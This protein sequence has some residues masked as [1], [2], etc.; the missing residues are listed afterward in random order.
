MLKLIWGIFVFCVKFL[1]WC[2]VWRSLSIVMKGY[3][4]KV[5]DCFEDDCFWIELIELECE[6]LLFVISYDIFLFLL[7]IN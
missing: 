5:V 3:R 2:M 4:G 7:I 6:D 1:K